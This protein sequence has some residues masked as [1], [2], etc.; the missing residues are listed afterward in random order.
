[1][2]LNSLD[3]LRGT[4]ALLIVLY[5]FNSWTFN[6][7]NSEGFLTRFG[8]YGVSLFYMLSGMTLFMIYEKKLFIKESLKDFFLKR[9]FRIL[10]LLWLVTFITIIFAKANFSFYQIFLNF[11]GLFSLLD[12]DGYIAGGA[13]SIGNEI[14]FYL[15]FPLI[16]YIFRRNKFWYFILLVLTIHVYF[17]FFLLDKSIPLSQ[18]WEVYINPLNHLFFFV[19]GILVFNLNR[20]IRLNGNLAIFLSVIFILLFVFYPVEGDSINLVYGYNKIIFTFFSIG[21][22]WSVLAWPELKIEF[23]AASL[24]WLG[25]ISYSVYLLHPIMWKLVSILFV[26]INVDS[27]FYLKIIV[28]LCCTLVFSSLIYKYYEVR[29]SKFGRKFIRN[30]QNG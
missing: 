25:D 5:H 1:M 2:R 9:A 22:T 6:V 27:N 24:K 7:H 4:S 20:Y 12:H 17:G 8:L 23:I 21:I 28:A 13:W 26:K 11:T 16:I 10:P 30:V 18:Q 19:S 29:M 3:Y 15:L 14:C